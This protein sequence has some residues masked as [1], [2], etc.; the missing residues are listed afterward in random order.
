MKTITAQITTELNGTPVSASAKV[1]FSHEEYGDDTDGNRGEKY[2]EFDSMGP[3][4]IIRDQVDITI[5]VEMAKDSFKGDYDKM[6]GLL[7]D[8]AMGEI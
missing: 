2:W 5:P 4:E 7:L 3:V 8:K 1:M 6:C